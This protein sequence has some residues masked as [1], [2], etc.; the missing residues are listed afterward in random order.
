MIRVM[1]VR[2]M[3]MPE[4]LDG[5]EKLLE[6]GTR[7]YA[8]QSEIEALEEYQRTLT[9]APRDR[10]ALIG[11][12]ETLHQLGRLDEALHASQRVIAVMPDQADG[13]IQ[14]G[15]VLYALQRYEDALGRYA[16]AR[17]RDPGHVTA[18]KHAGRT[19]LR[20][21]RYDEALAAYEQA[22][23]LMP[24]DFAILIGLG[25]AREALKHYDE[26]LEAYAQV[27]KLDPGQQE[28]TFHTGRLLLKHRGPLR[29]QVFAQNILK[30][31]QDNQA[32]WLIQG[33]ALMGTGSYLSALAAY[34][35]ATQLG[36][37]DP[38]GFRGKSRALACLGRQREADIAS[39][40]ARVLEK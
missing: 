15:D 38:R 32:A 24:H 5:L 14:L 3:T 40:Q 21:E 2:V 39:K 31:R 10:A 25:M 37:D 23:R 34:E 4:N 33:D 12:A 9:S 13:Y 8:S 20:L 17:N 18:Y 6:E 16:R 29:T 11:L 36:P 27:L 1:P 35:E 19:L 26:A 28:V 30:K 22:N 7:Y